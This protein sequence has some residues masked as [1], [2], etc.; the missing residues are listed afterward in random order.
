M[1]KPSGERPPRVFL[2]ANVIIAGCSFPRWSYEVLSHALKGDFQVV[3]CPLVIEQVRR[4]LKK[5]FPVSAQLRFEKFLDDT[6][7]EKVD[8]PAPEEIVKH[9][10]QSLPLMPQSGHRQSQDSYW[11]TVRARAAWPGGAGP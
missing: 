6:G 7:Y 1:A 2:D 3:L 5:D 8:N 4:H 11:R 9:E 10:H